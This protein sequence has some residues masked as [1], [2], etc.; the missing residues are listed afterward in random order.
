MATATTRPSTR[1]SSRYFSTEAVPSEKLPRNMI[2]LGSGK[3]SA[4]QNTTNSCSATISPPT[5]IRIWRR[6]V[7]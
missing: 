1:H 7:P 6:C 2:G 5:V 4:P 3:F